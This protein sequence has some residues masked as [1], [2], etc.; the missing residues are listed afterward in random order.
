MIEQGPGRQ[1][2]RDRDPR[3]SRR[4]RA[5][6]PHRR[7]LPLRG[8]QLAASPEGR[9][10]LPDRRARPPGQRLPRHRRDRSRWRRAAAPT[11][12]TP[13]TASCRR[14]RCSPR[15]ARRPGSP[16]SALRRRCCDLAGNKVRALEAARA[17]GLPTLRTG[18]GRTDVE[19]AARR[20]RRRSASRSS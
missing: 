11:R 10:G 8:P 13:A 7:G 20:R 3:L 14:T 1:P 12:S 15:P 17:A 2:W 4:L 6:H 18:P 5:R 16:S 9:R 19:R